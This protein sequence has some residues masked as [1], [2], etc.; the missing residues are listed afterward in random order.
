M[1]KL[2]TTSKISIIVPVCNVEEY[3]AKCLGSICSET[4]QNL[5]IIVVDDGSTDGCAAICDEWAAKDSRIKV[6]HCE[7]GGQSVARNRGLAVATGEFIGFV[8]GDDWVEPDM[9]QC[10]HNTLVNSNADISICSYYI[11]KADIS[12]ANTDTGRIHIMNAK[13]G[14]RGLIADNTYKNYLWNKLFKRE[15]FNG[16][17]FPEG[18]IFEDISVLY[19][20]FAGAKI[21]AYIE[22][23]LYH[24]IYR[25]G[26][27]LNVKYYDAEKEYHYLTALVDRACFLRDYDTELWELT[28]NRIVHKAVQLVDR[29][30][31]NHSNKKNNQHI[32]DECIK[33]LATVDMTKVRPDLRIKGWLVTRHLSLYK[34]LYVAFRKVLKSKQ[35][36]KKA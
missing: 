1:D 27:A 18:K 14:V 30:F 25:M 35:N 36:F 13:E 7:N 16:I 5:E 19:H 26:S 4:Y 24:Y 9:F 29:S 11:E 17:V 15:L 34:S 8:D 12:K 23:P 31:L 22:K 2:A 32:I 10:L 21:V 20:V 28:Q 3:L 6:L 33:G